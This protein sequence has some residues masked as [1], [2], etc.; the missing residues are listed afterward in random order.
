MNVV[1]VLDD[2]V[3]PVRVKVN[4]KILKDKRGRDRTFKNSINAAVAGAKEV[5]W[6]GDLV[7]DRRSS[8]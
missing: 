1:E 5:D 8:H 3:N 7:D 2:E 4:G 6:T